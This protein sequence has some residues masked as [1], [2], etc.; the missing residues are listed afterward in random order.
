MATR[1]RGREE[2]PTVAKKQKSTIPLNR[3]LSLIDPKE[4]G[5]LGEDEKELICNYK[6][7]DL[8]LIEN[9]SEKFRQIMHAKGVLEATLEAIID[10]S[11]RRDV[12]Y[13]RSETF[14]FYMPLAMSRRHYPEDGSISSEP[15]V[16]AEYDGSLRNTVKW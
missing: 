14:P 12:N 8:V 1:K 6:A 15:E 7:L 9:A 3:P 5:E 11:T 2:E 13:L 10:Q 16:K 4:F